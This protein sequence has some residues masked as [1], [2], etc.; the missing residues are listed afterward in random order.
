MKPVDANTG[1]TLNQS[2]LAPVH[3]RV[4]GDALAF[5]LCV[6]AQRLAEAMIA[7][8]GPDGEPI[9]MTT[10]RAESWTAEEARAVNEARHRIQIAMRNLKNR[11]L[12]NDRPPIGFDGAP[13]ELDS[14]GFAFEVQIT[15]EGL[16]YAKQHIAGTR[17]D[18][19]P[20]SV[21]AH[22]SAEVRRNAPAHAL[23]S[24]KNES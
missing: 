12:V 18:R 1:I 23:A 20:K 7:R 3:R 5:E 15:Q 19:G 24:F 11:R 21:L 4:H 2:D 6:S 22:A 13:M 16:S 17:F 9:A 10:I 8:T 14:N